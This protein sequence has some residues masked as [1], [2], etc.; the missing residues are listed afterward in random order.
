MTSIGSTIAY[1]IKIRIFVFL[2]HEVILKTVV[3]ALPTSD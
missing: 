2:S 1:K 3:S